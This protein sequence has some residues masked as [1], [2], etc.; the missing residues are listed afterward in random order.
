VGRKAETE[1]RAIARSL[2][3]WFE[4][5]ARDLPWRRTR[6]PYRIW[7]SE[8]MLQQTRVETV[9]GYYQR[10]LAHFPTV[11]AL[12]RAPLDE[13][14]KSWSGLGYY[15][16]ARQ[17]WRAA[18]AVAEHHGGRLPESA[19]ALEALEGVGRYTAGAIA[20]IAFGERAP[21][22]DGNVARVLAR[23]RGIDDDVRRG[24]GVR[25]LWEE[26]ERLVAVAG[27]P[28]RLNQALMELGATVCTP[29]APACARCPLGRRCVARASGRQDELPRAAEGRRAPRLP[30]VA[31]VV[32]RRDTGAVLLARR[33]S[34]GLFG[35]LWEPP[36]APAEGE[37]RAR[38][39]LR[40][41]GVPV[42]MTL[43]PAGE[44]RHAL[45]HRKLEIA[46]ARGT[47]ARGHA[48]PVAPRAPYDMLSW[49]R[50]EDVA[51]STLARKVLRRAAVL[52]TAVAASFFGVVAHAE[53]AARAAAAPGEPDTAGELGL[54]ELELYKRLSERPGG[55]ARLLA[56]AALGRGLR[57]NNP[58]R[59]RTQLGDSAESVSL[60]APYLDLGGAVAFGAPLGLQHGATLRLS[61]ALEGV[62]QQSI[63]ASYLALYRADLPLMAWGRAGPAL[64]TEPDVNVGG[65]L[66]VGGA[67]FV[68]GALGFGAE[69]V[70]NLFYGA[71]TEDARFTV[72]PILS[73][74]LGVVVDYEVLP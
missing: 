40:A 71:A 70:G 16:R 15:R 22:V 21:L 5:A 47:V 11:H 33:R 52:A 49:R 6:D 30:L 4:Q 39:E 10:F 31:A 24:A 18:R 38:S 8:V 61:I 3:R 42:R 26:A 25:R 65:E 7:V 1:A 34:E 63:G 12:G 51:L 48:L 53:P 57:F 50:A 45:T 72:I 64:L 73:G 56:T 74:Q 20:S 23:L 68:T 60:T 58:Y 35:G 27:E 36:M 62:A 17:L 13:V 14:L 9:C 59:L 69:I 19:R 44:V 32:V 37:R 67:V 46:V 28:G 55:Y 29:H 54:D 66:G 43:E 41:H 2:E